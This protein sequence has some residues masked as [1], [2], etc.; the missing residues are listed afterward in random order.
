MNHQTELTFRPGRYTNVLLILRGCVFP[1]VELWREK[2][3]N[4]YSIDPT[5]QPGLFGNE[6]GLLIK[7]QGILVVGEPAWAVGGPAWGVGEP[8]PGYWG[9]IPD[10]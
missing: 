5:N 9:T 8:S 7:R 2:G 4:Y 1:F 10:C 3:S 6:P